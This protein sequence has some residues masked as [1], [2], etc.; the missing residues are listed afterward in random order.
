MPFSNN[1]YSK[2]TTLSEYILEIEKDW[3]INSMAEKT[4]LCKAIQIFSRVIY[5]EWKRDSLYVY[6]YQFHSMLQIE[7]FRYTNLFFSFP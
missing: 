5:M 7:M 2:D 4:N 1:D 3:K 6:Y